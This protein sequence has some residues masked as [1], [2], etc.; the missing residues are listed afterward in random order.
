MALKERAQRREFRGGLDGVPL[1]VK[2]LD[3]K[4]RKLRETGLEF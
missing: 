2:R 1:V 4:A 3:G